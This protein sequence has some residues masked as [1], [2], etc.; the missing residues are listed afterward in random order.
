MNDNFLLELVAAPGVK[1]KAISGLLHP[2]TGIELTRWQQ[3]NFDNFFPYIYKCSN[4]VAV[5]IYVHTY[6]PISTYVY[7]APIMKTKKR[8]YCRLAPFAGGCP[9]SK[10]KL[11]SN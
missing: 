11:N 4:S 6:L 2:W 3:K 8:R 7:T 5:P 9:D 10:V 1:Q